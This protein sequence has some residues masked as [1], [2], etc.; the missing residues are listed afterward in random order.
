MPNVVYLDCNTDGRDCSNEASLVMAALV[1]QSLNDYTGELCLEDTRPIQSQTVALRVL[2]VLVVQ[3]QAFATG[4]QVC[5]DCL[6][7]QQL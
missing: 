3:V 7:P 4:E 5:L 2:G 6:P 1:L